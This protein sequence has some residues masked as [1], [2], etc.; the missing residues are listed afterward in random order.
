MAEKVAMIAASR[1]VNFPTAT[2]ISMKIA[3]I[4][5]TAFVKLPALNHSRLSNVTPYG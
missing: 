4:A 5:P 2:T 3:V 1:P